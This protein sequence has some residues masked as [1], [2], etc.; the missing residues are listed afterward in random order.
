MLDVLDLAQNLDRPE[1]R[2]GADHRPDPGKALPARY[3][4]VFVIID[5]H[6]VHGHSSQPPDKPTKSPAHLPSTKSQAHGGGHSSP[7]QPIRESSASSAGIYFLK[8][9][10]KCG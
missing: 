3:R 2:S 6:G 5:K 9:L 4:D 7:S 1:R 8:A 10:K